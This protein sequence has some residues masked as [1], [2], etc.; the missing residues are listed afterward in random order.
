[1]PRD[2]LFAFH[3]AAWTGSLLRS[4]AAIAFPSVALLGDKQPA[5]GI[6]LYL[7]EIIL[8]ALML[9]VRTSLSAWLV[10]RAVARGTADER[11]LS[12]LGKARDLAMVIVAVGVMGSPFLWVAVLLA[13]P[14]MHWQ[15]LRDTVIDRGQWI[16]AIVL[17]SAFLD[18]LV[19]PVRTPEWLQASVAM[20]MNRTVLLHPV[21]M[22]GYL[23]FAV[24]G[25]L[26]G[27]LV[28]F[29]VGRLLMDLNALRRGTRERA[30]KQWMQRGGMINW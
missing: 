4:G 17:A 24:T 28:I 20:Q 30:R 18:T 9:V 22:F 1:M 2:A 7:V 8:T 29:V 16:A 26:A 27:M 10:S 12:A 23:L 5:L 21:I 3:G 25:S 19:A 6:L 13:H 14:D 11:D 15:A